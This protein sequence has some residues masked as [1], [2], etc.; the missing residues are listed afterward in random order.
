[1]IQDGLNQPPE[2]EGE[3]DQKLEKI[4]LTEKSGAI[5]MGELLKRRHCINKIQYALCITTAIVLDI[6]HS[7]ADKAKMAS[8]A[9]TMC[10]NALILIT[11]NNFY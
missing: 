4:D 11:V 7:N 9:Q 5:G 1:M 8:M 6:L 3:L 2:P 10:V